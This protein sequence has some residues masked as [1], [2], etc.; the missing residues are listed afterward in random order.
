MKHGE[1]GMSSVG[2]WTEYVEGVILILFLFLGFRFKFSYNDSCFL[3]FVLAKNVLIVV[4]F[5]LF[6][7]D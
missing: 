1:C 6:V 3:E 7:A 4:V 2:L 5:L